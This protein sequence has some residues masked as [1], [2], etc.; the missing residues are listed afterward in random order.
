M[1]HVKK[2]AEI[3]KTTIAI[4]QLSLNPTY[5][6]LYVDC[7]KLCSFKDLSK[8]D[9]DSHNQMKRGKWSCS[10]HNHN[11]RSE[12]VSLSTNLFWYPGFTRSTPQQLGKA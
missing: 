8:R 9:N 4:D 11:R 3:E 1:F 10:D 2:C 12:T 7:C 5:K 6:S